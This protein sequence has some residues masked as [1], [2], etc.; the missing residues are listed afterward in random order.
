MDVQSG[1]KHNMHSNWKEWVK[2]SGFG[3]DTP[4]CV[5]NTNACILKYPT[6]TNQ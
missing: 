6:T 5:E 1:K 4:L 2:L 3:H